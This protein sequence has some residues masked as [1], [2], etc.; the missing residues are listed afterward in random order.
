M[1]Y[2]LLRTQKQIVD[3]LLWD[4]HIWC[5]MSSI[6]IG[7]LKQNQLT[8][9]GL[10]HL[11]P[12]NMKTNDWAWGKLSVFSHLCPRLALPLSGPPS[13]TVSL[14]LSLWVSIFIFLLMC[15]LLSHSVY[16]SIHIPCLCSTRCMCYIYG[17]ATWSGNI[18]NL[19]FMCTCVT[20]C[21]LRVYGIF[22]TNP[23]SGEICECS[24][25]YIYI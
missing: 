1:N 18:N 14:W 2:W 20:T 6:N 25:I 16:V 12:S 22:L 4:K 8:A 23:P 13:L 10:N 21:G 19:P 7:V 17:Y 15:I 24:C 5:L 3:L 11:L 9:T